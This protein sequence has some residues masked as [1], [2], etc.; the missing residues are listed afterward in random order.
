MP[1]EA[2]RVAELFHDC[3]HGFRIHKCAC[4]LAATHNAEAWDQMYAEKE[5]A[6]KTL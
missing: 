2:I 6:W 4:E 5:E 1:I 3:D